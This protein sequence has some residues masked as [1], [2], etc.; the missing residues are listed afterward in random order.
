MS[1]Y[2][3][4]LLSNVHHTVFYTGFTNDL[5]RRIDEHKHQVYKGYTKKYNCQKL[6][7]NEEFADAPTALQREQQLK[8]YKRE[9][10]ENLIN[11]IN[12]EWRDLYEDFI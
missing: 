6:L 11:S 10:K 8:R 4:Y 3:V 2:Y 7:Y 12:P 1:N 5:Q 9:C